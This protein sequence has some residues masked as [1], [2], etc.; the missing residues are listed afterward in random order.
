MERFYRNLLGRREDG[1]ARMPKAEALAEAKAWLR[2]QSAADE[3]ATRSDPRPSRKAPS[4]ARPA[5][6]RFDHP[7]YWAGFILIGDPN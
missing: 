6:T 2:T 3:P 1:T 7:Y 4:P 5:V